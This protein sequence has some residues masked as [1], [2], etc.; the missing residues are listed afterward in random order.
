M[1]KAAAAAGNH[2]MSKAKQS[3][4]TCFFCRARNKTSSLFCEN[5]QKI[6]PANTDFFSKFG[7]QE[8][9]T[10]DTEDLNKKYL[11]MQSKTHPDLFVKKSE[12]EQT[13]ALTVSSYLNDAYKILK[14]DIARSKYILEL[15]NIDLEQTAQTYLKTDPEFLEEVMDLNE[16]KMD[17]SNDDD[18]EIFLQKLQNKIQKARLNIV[19]SFN[20]KQYEQAAIDTIKLK[21]YQ[22]ASTR[23]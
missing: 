5:C 13:L 14:D 17:I 21:Y 11:S 3:D 4:I 10:I 22:K 18:Q 8:S 2:F 15:H 1:R 23:I 7:Y 6:L 16:E 12:I 9:F 20:K 19:D